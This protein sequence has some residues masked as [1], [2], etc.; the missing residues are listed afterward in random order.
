VSDAFV[1]LKSVFAESA[2]EEES[3]IV[4]SEVVFRVSFNEDPLS[5]PTFDESGLPDDSAG[6]LVDPLRLIFGADSQEQMPAIQHT[7]ANVN[8]FR[9][10][11]DLM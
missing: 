7:S 2:A 11:P 4:E 10:E 1:E 9:R 3:V 8:H 5:P 6:P